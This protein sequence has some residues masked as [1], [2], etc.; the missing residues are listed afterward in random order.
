MN[1]L[2]SAYVILFRMI[3]NIDINENA[4][5]ISCLSMTT[6][7]DAQGSGICSNLYNIIFFLITKRKIKS[8]LFVHTR[9]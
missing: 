6:D 3:L 4:L 1:G 2:F 9:S 5:T 7:K 8:L